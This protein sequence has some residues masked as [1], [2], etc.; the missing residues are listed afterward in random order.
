MTS[1]TPRIPSPKMFP[2]ISG[3]AI[4]VKTGKKGKGC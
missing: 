2:A 3:K 1:K 4:K